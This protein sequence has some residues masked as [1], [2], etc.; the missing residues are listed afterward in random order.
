MTPDRRQQ[1]EAALRS[2][3]YWYRLCQE[4][5]LDLRRLAFYRWL[6]Q[7]GRLTDGQEVDETTAQHRTG[8]QPERKGNEQ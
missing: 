7:T 1:E 8:Q 4:M 3:L 2:I 6:V 5:G